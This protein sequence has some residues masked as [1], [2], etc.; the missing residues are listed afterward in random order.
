MMMMM[1][2]IIIIIIQKPR[3]LD[4]MISKC[5]RHNRH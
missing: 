4:N 2:M 5:K 3:T 1:M